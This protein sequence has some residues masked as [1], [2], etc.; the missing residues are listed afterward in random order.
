MFFIQVKN[1]WTGQLAGAI[2]ET[3]SEA[4]DMVLQEKG[5]KP[6]DVQIVVREQ[7]DPSLYR[8]EDLKG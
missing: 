7:I 1:S 4:F 5:W 8:Q 3:D 6:W 2:S